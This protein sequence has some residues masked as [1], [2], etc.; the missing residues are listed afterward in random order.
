[1]KVTLLQTDITWSQPEV[2]IRRADALLRANG[3]SDLYVLP[4]MWA[5]GFATEPEGIAEA[6]DGSFA[7]QWMREVA[8]ECGCAVCGSL[9]VRCAD[10]SFR[11]RHY[12]CTPDALFFYDKHHLFTYGHEDHFYTAGQQRCIVEWRGCRFLLVTCYDLRFPL[13]SRYTAEAPFDVILVVANWP[14]SRQTAWEVLTRARA[15]ENQSY[16]VGVNRVGDDCYSHYQ[17]ASRVVDA[18]GDVVGLCA[19]NV[20]QAIT[21]ELNLDAQRTMRERFRVLDDADSFRLL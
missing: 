7:L 9:A 2:N 6:E 11:N 4:E 17:G 10:G 12:F 20:E 19:D 18:R 1:M 21:I 3:G 13:W 8:R 14:Q 16:L 5:T 15:I